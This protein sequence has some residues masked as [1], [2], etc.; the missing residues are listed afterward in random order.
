MSTPKF[1]FYF[2]SSQLKKDALF[3]ICA[4]SMEYVN[5]SHMHLSI[6]AVYYYILDVPSQSLRVKESII[7][8]KNCLSKNFQAFEIKAFGIWIRLELSCILSLK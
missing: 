5:L 4:Y 1:I 3:V 2:C 6:Y 7:V 8:F